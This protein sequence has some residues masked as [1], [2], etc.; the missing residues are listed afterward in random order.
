MAHLS[1]YLFICCILRGQG[2]LCR[3]LAHDLNPGPV[4]LGQKLSA[5]YADAMWAVVV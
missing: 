2:D 3:G 5:P 1:R 4:V